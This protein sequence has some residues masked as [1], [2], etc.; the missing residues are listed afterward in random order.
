MKKLV[1]ISTLF[2]L[3][4]SIACGQ[5]TNGLVAYYSFDTNALP[6]PDNSGNGNT[7]TVNSAT[8]TNA[9]ILGGA[10]VFD[11]SNDWIQTAAN[12]FPTGAIGITYSLWVK[13]GDNPLADHRLL[14]YGLDAAGRNV[15][16]YIDAN[17]YAIDYAGGQKSILSG[18]VSIGIWQYVTLTQNGN[19]HSFYI[20]GVLQ[21]T[22]SHVLDI[23]QS[24]VMQIGR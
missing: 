18:T 23:G 22:G 20:N 4:V 24:N 1:E 17:C 13:P 11:G 14:E 9:G 3:S 12:G 8:W 5:S 16:F 21:T 10:Y 7:G 2:L 19:A 6:V 15:N